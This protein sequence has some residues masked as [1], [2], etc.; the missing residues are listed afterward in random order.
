MDIVTQ[1][2]SKATFPAYLSGGGEMGERIRNFDWRKSPLGPIEK[3]PQ[4]LR[5]T[6]SICLN[7][8]FPILIWWG[9][10][11][12]KIYNDAYSVIISTKHPNALG[13]K[14][15]AVWPEIWPIIGPMLKS[16]IE[17]GQA[18]WSENL[19]LL[20]H[21]KGFAEECY[22][23]FSYSPIRE[24]SN[25]VGGV[26]S[27][28]TETTEAVTGERQLK[29]LQDLAQKIS[30]AKDERDV[31]DKAVE[32]IAQNPKDFP[33]FMLHQAM[34]DGTLLQI[35]ANDASASG[36]K[37]HIRE[38]ISTQRPVVKDNSGNEAQLACGPWK[39]P[40]NKI[41]ALPVTTGNPKT[42]YAV[43]EIGVNPHRLLDEKYTSFYKLVVHHIATGISNARTLE[44]ERKKAEALEQI[45][46]AKT[47]F[48]SNI[49]HEFRTPITLMLGPLEELLEKATN[50]NT[51]ERQSLETTHRNGLR[52]LK[53]VNTLLDFSRIESGR[54]Q[55][56]F[57]PVDLSTYTGN[58]A[59]NF[60]SL[61]E[62][63]GLQF[64]FT[65][66]S[67]SHAV[68]VD[69]QMWEKIIFNLLSNAFKY[70]LKGSITVSLTSADR[71]AELCV[72]DTGVGIPEEELPNMFERFHRV[73]NS[74]ARTYEGSGIGLSL[75][76]E[77]V[78][79]HGGT[80][81]VE[82]KT[83][84][85]TSFR[86][87]IPLGK[88]HLPPAL[89]SEGNEHTSTIP[90]GYLEEAAALLQRPASISD[91]G[92]AIHKRA[93]VLVVDDNADMRFHLQRLL[94]EEFRVVL[95]SDGRDA[96]DKIKTER[97]ALVLSDIMMPVM[98]GLELLKEV[99]NSSE[100]SGIPV[101]LITARAGEE[102]R[103]EGYDSG[104]DDYLVKPFSSKE[105]LARIRSQLH[106][107]AIREKARKTLEE[108]EKKFRS[109]LQQSPS[110]FLILS[111]P[112]FTITFGNEPLFQSWGK[113]NDIIGKPLLEVLPELADQPFPQLLRQVYNTGQTHTGREEKAVVIK[114]GMPQEVYYNYVYQPVL[115]EANNVTAVTV[116]ASDVTD[117]VLV[118]KKIEEIASQFRTLA[119]SLPAFVWMTDAAGSIE[120]I[121][122]RWKEYS[123]FDTVNTD[124]WHQLV[125]P[126]DMDAIMS[127]W[128]R[129][130]Q[131]ANTYRGEIRIRNTKGEYRW[132]FAHGVPV[133][134][135][136]GVVLK[137]I[138]S[139][140]DIHDQKLF[141]NNLISLVEERTSDLKRSNDDL[142]QFAHVAS[143]DLKEP[144]R[145]IQTFTSFLIDDYETHLPE[146]GK[147]YLHKI[148]AAINRIYDMIEGV[149]NYSSLNGQP[150]QHEL[151]D[152]NKVFQR[153]DADFELTI[154]QTA[155][156]LHYSN[157]PVVE[158]SQTLVYQ[159][160]SNLV[161]NS[162]KF[163]R[164]G[165]PAV[166]TI[167]SAP[168]ETLPPDPALLTG[169]RY[170]K[171]LIRDN[172]I[173]FDQKF[174]E[175][176]FS[177][178]TRLNSKDKFEGTGLGLALCKKIVERMHGS[179]SAT[180]RENEGAVF[181]VLLPLPVFE[182][183]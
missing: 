76:R 155:A 36:G 98:D 153:I 111:G 120:Y 99:R 34:G 10:D 43:L 109:V 169:K 26:F 116:M 80:I 127:A 167:T 92:E 154:E 57:T 152:L 91:N 137:W 172:G 9:K 150:D 125:H 130:L 48:F 93:T 3:W 37:A 131:N 29:T 139:F 42:P 59:A 103:I 41:L 95:A 133:K 58:L 21:R 16:V 67:D 60:R 171:I 162:L 147:M 45:D 174:A 121:S 105:L 138:G 83:G 68:Y 104:A 4:S 87:R 113:T 143:H 142:Q 13:T 69:K 64:I 17:E 31:Y 77:F 112:E 163:T 55:A 19:L 182:K 53:L 114:N 84:Q 96:L 101:I 140:T 168:A 160:F 22:F 5:T 1:V 24:E 161:G 145:K 89:I 177:P 110:I 123:G 27:A 106:I 49:S 86:V 175:K 32:V 149:L 35:P 157:L 11:H 165:K 72:T 14:G 141:S 178:F 151:T 100:T 164:P 146:K 122:R 183:E 124:I 56:S 52:L 7:S 79:L 173:G 115:D 158:A 119:E 181:E 2:R 71:Y 70:T 148:E 126:D 28:I 47:A 78:R 166:V 46:K 97:P 12:V 39:I 88:E 6:V 74:V 108:N 40:A 156:T 129:S 144:V 180:G 23:T 170:V 8:K 82:S 73:K 81:S 179:I 136:E 25:A 85:G 50:L 44:E 54:Y 134:N 51:H 132:H 176:I 75:V 90:G 15:E 38:A 102:S 117:Q 65:A 118:R 20:L 30:E 107:T 128:T 159:L 94:A 63:A 33:F 62:K 61:I 18:T 66:S 135:N